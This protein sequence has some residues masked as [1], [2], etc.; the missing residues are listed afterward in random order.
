MSAH[1]AHSPGWGGG[2]PFDPSRSGLT[3]LAQ[4]RAARSNRPSMF[5]RSHTW[6]TVGSGPALRVGLFP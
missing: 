6:E 5:D 1:P 3:R 4:A 2:N